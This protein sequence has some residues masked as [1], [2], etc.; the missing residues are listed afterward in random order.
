M[1][2]DAPLPEHEF[3]V[4]PRS[5]GFTSEDQPMYRIELSPGEQT[6]FRT[7]EEL[8]TGIRNGVIT[9]RSRIFHGASQKWLPIEFHPHYRKALDSL[10]HPTGQSAPSRT[11]TPTRNEGSIQKETLSRAAE[12]AVKPKAAMAPRPA[13]K[14]VPPPPPLLRPTAGTDLEIPSFAKGLTPAAVLERDPAEGATLDPAAGGG[15]AKVLEPETETKSRWR[16]RRGPRPIRIAIVGLGIVICSQVVISAASTSADQQGHAAAGLSATGDT[17][18]TAA[19]STAGGLAMV[20]ASRTDAG[21]G[22]GSGG[23]TDAAAGTSSPASAAGQG[24]V[25]L[26]HRS[27]SARQVQG[28]REGWAGDSREASAQGMSAGP[29]F[30]PAILASSVSATPGTPSAPSPMPA[31]PTR[32]AS[33][34]AIALAPAPDAIDL[35]LPSLPA[36]SIPATGLGRDS[37]AMRRILRALNGK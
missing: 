23:R 17:D 37:T 5:Q 36:D 10:N 18:A 24:A 12:P 25:N 9:P 34:S 14:P 29:A 27:P 4:I 1:Q 8:A 33:D 35:S 6:V 19:A 30:A 16:R 32:P 13:A 2:G 7:I 28:S 15:P 26:V 31:A 11:D 3:G 22:K 21:M 20:D